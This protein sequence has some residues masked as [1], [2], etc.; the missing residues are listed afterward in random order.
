MI[1]ILYSYHGKRLRLF[2]SSKNLAHGI[3]IFLKDQ[4]FTDIVLSE[5]KSKITK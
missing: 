3:E 1:I 5:V 2:L 4:K